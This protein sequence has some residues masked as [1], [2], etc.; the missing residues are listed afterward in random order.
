MIMQQGGGSGAGFHVC[1]SGGYAGLY[2]NRGAMLAACMEALL[3]G[4]ITG[5]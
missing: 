3:A 4:V 5:R 2:V 1:L